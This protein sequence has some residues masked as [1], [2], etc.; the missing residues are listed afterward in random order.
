M[1]HIGNATYGRGP[2]QILTQKSKPFIGLHAFSR[3]CVTDNRMESAGM[4]AGR[5]WPPVSANH[6]L[7]LDFDGTLVDIVGRPDAVTVPQDLPKLISYVQDKLGGALCIVTGRTIEDI[8]HFLRLPN[9]DVAAEHGAAF[10]VGGQQGRI[11]PPY[12]HAW[13]EV[14]RKAEARV[15]ELVVERKVSSVALHYR[16]APEMEREAGA[17]AEDLLAKTHG[18]YVSQTSNMTIEVKRADVNKGTAIRAV[19]SRAPYRGRTPVFVADDAFDE[20]GFEAVNHMHG[21]A[22]HVHEH[23]SGNTARVHEWLSS[24]L[25]LEENAHV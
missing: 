12:P 19:M 5:D 17:I 16:L 15:K 7:L 8:D 10:R 1:L 14:L 4:K 20:R 13:D 22:L 11:V 9:C 23:F 21:L 25:K 3:I 24:Y 18:G 6:A 2:P